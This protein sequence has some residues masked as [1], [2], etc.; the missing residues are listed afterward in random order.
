MTSIGSQQQRPYSS[1]ILCVVY[2][3]VNAIE[4][5]REDGSMY[6]G[7]LGSER[8]VLPSPPASKGHLS[9]TRSRS[10]NCFLEPLSSPLCSTARYPHGAV[11]EA[12]LFTVVHWSSLLLL[13][14]PPSNAHPH[15]ATSIYQQHWTI[16]S[17]LALESEVQ[18]PPLLRVLG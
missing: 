1:G 9:H 5:L 15:L 4:A 6:A 10:S 11:A 7:I 17:A 18:T 13:H 16:C 8:R 14:L 2:N 12:R 3:E